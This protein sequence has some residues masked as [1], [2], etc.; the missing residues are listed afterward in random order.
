MKDET[1]ARVETETENW[2][3]MAELPMDW[4]GFR[5]LRQMK[6]N[7]DMYDLYSYVNEKNNRSVTVY[8]H[9]ETKEYKVREKVGL[10]EFC[11][12]EFITSEFA[13]FERLLKQHFEDMMQELSVFDRKTIS[14]TVM[15]KGIL[16]WEYGKSL[17]ESLEGFQLFTHPAEPL[18]ITNGSYILFDYSDFSIE[19]N[20]II[21]YNMYRDEFCGE[22][23]IHRIPD[24]NYLF[25]S[26]TLPELEEKLSRH[27]VPRLQEIRRRAEEEVGK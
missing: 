15:E 20:F 19:S 1:K 2:A 17:P 13:S 25:D 18:R 6:I 7:G 11:R 22:A 5:L 9:E 4:H 14:S 23:R 10:I 8:F 27:L 26:T 24:V 16:E 3:Y 21:Y 12:I